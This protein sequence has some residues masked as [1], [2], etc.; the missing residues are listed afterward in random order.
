MATQ[1]QIKDAIALLEANK[2]FVCTENERDHLWSEEEHE[3]CESE[4]IGELWTENEK[5][6]EENEKL[7]KENG[8]LKAKNG[9]VLTRALDDYL[10]NA[11]KDQLINFDDANYEYFWAATNGDVVFWKVPSELYAVSHPQEEGHSRVQSA[12]MDELFGDEWGCLSSFGVRT[13]D[14]PTLADID[15]E[16]EE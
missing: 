15:G 7:K 1:Q 6:K 10:T 9:E 4:E 11:K 12:F 8:E 13:L 5:L 2:Y 14:M 3:A 16:G